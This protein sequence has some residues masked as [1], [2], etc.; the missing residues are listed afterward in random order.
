MTYRHRNDVEIVL[1][2]SRLL[3]RTL[4][5]SPT[6]VDRVEMAYARTLQRL[7]PDRLKFGAVHPA[8][9]YGRLSQSQV[10]RFLDATEQRWEQGGSDESKTQ[11][12]RTALT[13]CIALTPRTVPPPTGP[14]IL[15]QASPHHLER[16]N[17]VE[18]KL[19]REQAQFVCLVH[20][21]IPV[22]YPEYARPGG[23]ATH[24]QRLETLLTL[25][26]GLLT[27]S[28]ATADAMQRYA[29]EGF[30]VRRLRVAPLAVAN[31]P[32]P[33]RVHPFAGKDYFLCV[34]TI[35]PRKNH[36]LLLKLWRSLAEALGPERTPHL[37]LVGRRGWENENVLDMLERCDVLKGVVHELQR[38]PD[39]DLW[40][41]IHHARALL[42]PSFAEGFGLPVIE[43]LSCGVPVL[44]SDLPAHREAGGSVPDY[45]DPLDGVGWRRAILD[46]SAAASVG[47][48]AQI[49]R[50][51][52]WRPPSWESHIDT[53]LALA[54][55]VVTC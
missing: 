12:W 46:Y 19:L 22:T 53:A 50:M 14:R 27:N 43:A 28:R 44:A 7:I 34:G 49:D 11:S 51:A 15:L 30:D 39:R 9:V 6:G 17:V 40:P 2:L 41:L 52:S 35:E 4:H 13:Q 54:E 20:D 32:I 55:E 18:A 25:A 5:P 23:A 3:S 37:I 36:L 38:L 33:D 45:L 31:C 26:D 29:G 21:L 1:D 16:R 42:M 8:G 24:H 47:R 10:A 48:Q